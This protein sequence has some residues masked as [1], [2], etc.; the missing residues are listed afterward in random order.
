M[1]NLFA[2]ALLVGIAYMLSKTHK[3]ESNQA[4]VTNEPNA[5]I[6]SVPF[7]F[8]DQLWAETSDYGSG[9]GARRMR[10]EPIEREL[11]TT[12]FTPE[13]LEA[14]NRQQ[15]S[16]ENQYWLNNSHPLMDM[17]HLF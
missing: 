17:R 12:S 14:M 4:M 7:K 9:S 11:I 10:I 2:P 8:E 6:P 15:I 5:I 13:L 16:F 1:G 3:L